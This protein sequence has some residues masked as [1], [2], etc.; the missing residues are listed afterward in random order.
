[1]DGRQDI[2][3]SIY[4]QLLNMVKVGS[5]CTTSFI[6]FVVQHKSYIVNGSFSPTYGVI[7]CVNLSLITNFIV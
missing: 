2:R 3:Q 7:G 6:T 5:H 4:N 1:M